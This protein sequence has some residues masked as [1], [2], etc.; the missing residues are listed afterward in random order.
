MKLGQGVKQLGLQ[1]QVKR[2]VVS[3]K[4][5]DNYTRQ[6]NTETELYA[7]TQVANSMTGKVSEIATEMLVF[8]VIPLGA[9][10]KGAKFSRIVYS[11]AASGAIT[12][13]IMPVADGRIETRL[14]NAAIGGVAG[15]TITVGIYGAGKAIMPIFQAAK[16]VI[17]KTY[18]LAKGISN[19]YE[20]RSPILIEPPKGTMLYSFPGGVVD[21]IKLRN[22]V[23]KRVETKS[24]YH[25]Y[26]AEPKILSGF[27][28]AR[29]AKK[30]GITRW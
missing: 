3:Q 15:A 30:I 5:L 21:G 24:N 14:Q 7:R 8:S 10:V 6:I 25:A 4:E 23:K 29:I 18:N 17:A 9:T 1:V 19:K 22:P 28:E 26:H 20:I 13:A 2:G 27:P 11:S 12:A 16:P